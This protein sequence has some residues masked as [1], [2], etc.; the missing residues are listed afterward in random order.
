MLS[1]PFIVIIIIV[2]LLYFIYQLYNFFSYAPES[3]P[4]WGRPLPC[5]DYWIHKGNNV[6]M[7][8]LQ[9]GTGYPDGKKII[10]EYNMSRLP[11]C[12]SGKEN[13]KECLRAKCDFAQVSNNPWFGVQPNC[14]ETGKC[15][16]PF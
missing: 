10:S 12:L 6:C 1:F 2:L 15:Y 5:P 16:C 3:W 4:P 9:L 8:P 13:S 11:G 14:K 7:N